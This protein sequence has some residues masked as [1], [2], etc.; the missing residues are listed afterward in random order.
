MSANKVL[1]SSF[2]KNIT[3]S[4]RSID[5][6]FATQTETWNRSQLA[7]SM[8]DAFVEAVKKADVPA[9]A[10]TAIMA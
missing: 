1:A 2:I 10:T 5:C 4:G 9:N 8:Q 7:E 6:K 3:K